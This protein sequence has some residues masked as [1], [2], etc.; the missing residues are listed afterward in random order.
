VVSPKNPEESLILRVLQSDADPHMPPKKQLAP[1]QVG[2]LRDWVQ[3]GTP[4]DEAAL[5]QDPAR[6][7]VNPTSAIRDRVRA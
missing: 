4:W 1:R 5:R 6:A 7:E 2:I 3:A